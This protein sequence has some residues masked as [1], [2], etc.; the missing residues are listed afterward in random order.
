MAPCQ[1]EKGFQVPNY[2]KFLFTL[3]DNGEKKFICEHDLFVAMQNIKPE[4]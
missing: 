2:M 3:L 1:V 4:R